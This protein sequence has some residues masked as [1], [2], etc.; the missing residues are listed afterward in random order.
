VKV[1]IAGGRDFDNGAM[2]IQA[3]EG[4]EVMYGKIT[5]IVCGMARGADMMGFNYGSMRGIP[6]KEFPADWDRYGKMAGYYR[7][8][9]MA[10]Y[11]QGLIAFW[12]K[13]SKGT[14][15]MIEL[16]KAHYLKI[17]IAHY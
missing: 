2:F 10:T 15:M 11:A 14:G 9:E 6:V 5:E 13:K 7:N 17:L 3:V 8:A 12:D 4:F 1:I 16:A